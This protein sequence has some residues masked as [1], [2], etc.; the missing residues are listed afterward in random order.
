MSPLPSRVVLLSGSPPLDPFA[1][2]SGADRGQDTDRGAKHEGDGERRRAGQQRVVLFDDLS[3]PA[4][5]V[6]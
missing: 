3:A 2:P 6:P 5:N 4:G 1:E